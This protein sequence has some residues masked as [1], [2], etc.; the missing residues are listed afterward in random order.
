M[1]TYNLPKMYTQFTR[2]TAEVLNQVLSL[3]T[4]SSLL[5]YQ[6]AFTQRINTF[7]KAYNRMIHITIPPASQTS[8]Q[9]ETANLCP[10]CTAV[11]LS[12]PHFRSQISFLM[13]KP[14]LS[15]CFSLRSC[16]FLY[17]TYVL[18]TAGIILYE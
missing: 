4:R 2:D 11:L 7:P 15:L 6:N 16:G 17:R 13:S 12:S 10:I 9:C 18:T 1:M 14:P 3:R 8:C 5:S